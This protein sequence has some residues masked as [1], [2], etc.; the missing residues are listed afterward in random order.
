MCSD[1][2]PLLAFGP[3][4]FHGAWCI[5]LLVGWLVLNTP[6]HCKSGAKYDVSLAGLFFT[7]LANFILGVLLIHEGLKGSFPHN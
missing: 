7:F 3:T 4:V 6:S 1:D 2:V 5:V